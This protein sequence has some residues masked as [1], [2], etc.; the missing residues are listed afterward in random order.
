MGFNI[1][2]LKGSKLVVPPDFQTSKNSEIKEVPILEGRY[3]SGP[4]TRNRAS[5]KPVRQKLRVLIN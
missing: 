5:R 2:L 4:S 1:Y 3:F